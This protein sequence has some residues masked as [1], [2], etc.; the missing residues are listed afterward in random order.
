MEWRLQLCSHEYNWT[1]II[2]PPGS[3]NRTHSHRRQNLT[4]LLRSLPSLPAPEPGQ[5]PA[6]PSES[7]CNYARDKNKRRM[8]WMDYGGGALT[9]A[10]DPS[11][12]AIERP[13]DR[14]SERAEH[15]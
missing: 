1:S 14:A 9:D 10:P 13:S 3:T 8:T 4:T 15:E 12:Q 7:T 11:E 2:I 5:S 6:Q